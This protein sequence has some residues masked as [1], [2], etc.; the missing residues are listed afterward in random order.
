MLLVCNSGKH[1]ILMLQV[2][3]VSQFSGSVANALNQYI[4]LNTILEHDPLST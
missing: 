1:G 3:L 4:T 2:R